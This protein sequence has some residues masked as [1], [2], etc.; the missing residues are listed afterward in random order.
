MSIV[1]GIAEI[2]D[3]IVIV[4]TGGVLALPPEL[5]SFIIVN[6]MV[7]PETIS[8]MIDLYDGE[9][10]ALFDFLPL[11]D[12]ISDVVQVGYR[13]ILCFFMFFVPDSVVLERMM[14]VISRDYGELSIGM[15]FSYNQAGQMHTFED[16]YQMYS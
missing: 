13:D 6:F 9:G 7:L 11:P 4:L 5:Y 15:S 10:I 3:A 2:I 14:N 12:G 16:G 1:N 8:N